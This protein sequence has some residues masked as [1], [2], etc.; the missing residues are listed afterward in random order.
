MMSE[1]D[2]G[3]DG[4]TVFRGVLDAALLTEIDGHIGWCSARRPDT[5]PEHLVL[6]DAF[7]A[8]LVSDPRLLDVQ[9]A[10]ESL[11]QISMTSEPNENRQRIA[12]GAENLVAVTVAVTRRKS[13]AAK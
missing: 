8:R 4:Y 6:H 9:G 2:F 5:R 7:M 12:A 13:N 1:G 3:R 11:P 10:V